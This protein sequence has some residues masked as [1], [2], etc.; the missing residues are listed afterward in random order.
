MFYSDM[1]T[2]LIDNWQRNNVLLNSVTGIPGH[3]WINF[4]CPALFPDLPRFTSIIS[5][6]F[7]LFMVYFFV[8]DS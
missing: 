5:A 3:P 2:L 6:F 7:R 4:Y 1:I 8:L